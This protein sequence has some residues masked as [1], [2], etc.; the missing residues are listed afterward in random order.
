MRAHAVIERTLGV[1]SASITHARPWRAR[2]RRRAHRSPHWRGN[3]RAGRPGR[4]LR[5]PRRL[6]LVGNRRGRRHRILRPEPARLP[7]TLG[8]GKPRASFIFA[9]CAG[10]WTTDVIKN[11]LSSLSSSTTL[12]S[13]TIGG[14][15]VGFS[16]DHANLRTRLDKRLRKRRRRG[17]ENREHQSSPASSTPCWPAFAPTRPTRRSSPRPSRLLRPRRLVLHRPLR[18]HHQ[19]LDSG[20]DIL[21]GVIKKAAAANGDAFADVRSA[22]SRPRTVRLGRLAALGHLADRQLLP[23]DRGR[24]AGRL[25]PGAQRR[26]KQGRPVRPA[27]RRGG[28]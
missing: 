23:S 27:A 26:G 8:G 19:A 12:V 10:A 2:A 6:V 13:I 1:V 20:I 28:P 14:N 17:R 11:Q 24:P 5:R 7:G 4:Q 21:D 3:A 18:R 9:A 15:D 16:F 25:P 22:F